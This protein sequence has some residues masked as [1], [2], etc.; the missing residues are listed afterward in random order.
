MVLCGLVAGRFFKGLRIGF[1]AA[2][3]V[4]VALAGGFYWKISHPRGD[5]R[6]ELPDHS[7]ALKSE[8]G[9]KLLSGASSAD[10]PA[11]SQTFQVQQKGSWCGV[12][13]AVTV[14]NADGGNLTQKS[15]FTEE[16]TDVRPWWA[17]TFAGMPLGDLAGMLEAHGA[18]ATVKHARASTEAAFQ[19]SLKSNM[20]DPS[21]WLIVN[22]DRDVLGEQGGGHISPVSAYSAEKNM[23]L[24][25]DTARYKYPFHWV[26]VS[27]LFE[28]MKTSD[29]ETGQSRGWV[30]VR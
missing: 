11:L 17:T 14:L 26:P 5:G 13:S 12:A 15:F 20:N 21:N 6:L 4:T 10:H 16:V 8:A 22:Y 25:L 27:L 23:V 29:S 30:V 2:V 7:V 24:L 28:A 19:A 1:G 3:V 9:Q 18:E